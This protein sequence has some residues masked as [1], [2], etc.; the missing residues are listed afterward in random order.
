MEA[1]N[2][3]IQY[4]LT[5]LLLQCRDSSVLHHAWFVCCRAS[6]KAASEHKTAW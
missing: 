6:L 5:I 3:Y 2:K 4:E 1:A